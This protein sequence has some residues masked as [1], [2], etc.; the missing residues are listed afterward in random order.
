MSIVTF[1]G[2][3][4]AGDVLNTTGT[5]AGT[6]KNVGFC[7]MAQTNTTTLTQAGIATALA[8]N[9]VIPA[10]SHILNIQ[11]LVFDAFS[12]SGTISVGTSAT[13]TELVAATAV[14]AVGLLSLNPGTDKTRTQKWSNTGTS[15]SII[16]VLA[17]ATGTGTFDIVVRYIQAE[18]A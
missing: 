13:A 9:I 8:T 2:P 5:T 6:I 11:L 14:S 4:K 7:G 3:I 15:D 16:Y 12:S 18:N 1:T 10:N 17:S